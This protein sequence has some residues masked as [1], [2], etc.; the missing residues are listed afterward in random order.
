MKA[1]TLLLLFG[2]VF[3]GACKKNQ[4][5]LRDDADL[6]GEYEW[7]Y[8]YGAGNVSESFE[9]ITDNYGIVLK[10]N[11][12]AKVYKNNEEVMDGYVVESYSNSENQ[13]TLMLILNG[14]DVFFTFWEDQLE[15]NSYPIENQTN[16]FQKQ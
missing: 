6:I 1:L 15:W 12:K 11:G 7:A 9:T 5:N 10:K 4:I 8:S 3:L 2:A 13:K 14:D 16:L